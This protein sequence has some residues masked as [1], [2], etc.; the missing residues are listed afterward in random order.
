[1]FR[2]HYKKKPVMFTFDLN[3]TVL[4]YEFESHFPHVATTNHYFKRISFS[5]QNEFSSI[6]FL[7]DFFELQKL[8]F[9]SEEIILSIFHKHNVFK[10][11]MIYF[12]HTKWKTTKRKGTTSS[13]SIKVYNRKLKT[14]PNKPYDRVDKVPKAY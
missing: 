1:M 7:S 5:S 4:S 13:E 8:G 2:P 14:G 9:N 3:G 12:F 11:R 6:F 10:P